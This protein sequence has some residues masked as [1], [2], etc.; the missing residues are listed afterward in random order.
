MIETEKSLHCD[1]MLPLV[2]KITFKKDKISIL[3]CFDSF[4]SDEI[5]NLSENTSMAIVPIGIAKGVSINSGIEFLEKLSSKK[6]MTNH[7]K[8][9]EDLENFKK[10]INNDNR[11]IYMNWDE[12]KEVKL[13]QVEI[14]RNF[15]NKVQIQVKERERNFNFFS[16]ANSRS[17]LNY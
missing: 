2:Y 1:Y 16:F 7:F 10:L 6:F 11:F 15:P 17:G 14:K 12:S 3:H 9:Y 4:I 5:I 13:E 8:S